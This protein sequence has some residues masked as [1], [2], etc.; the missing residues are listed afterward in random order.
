MKQ[1]SRLLRTL[2]P[3]CFGTLSQSQQMPYHGPK[4][5]V[6]RRAVESGDA[7]HKYKENLAGL[8]LFLG[9]NLLC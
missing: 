3:A 6:G 2:V 7:S 1:M 8:F 4:L 5:A 9:H